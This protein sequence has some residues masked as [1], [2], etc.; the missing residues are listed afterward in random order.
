MPR[1]RGSLR[2][3]GDYPPNSTLLT[4]SVTNQTFALSFRW[5]SVHIV[6]G[7]DED[8][9][10]VEDRLLRAGE[11]AWMRYDE[12]CQPE[13]RR[14]FQTNLPFRLKRGNP[15]PFSVMT[16]VERSPSTCESDYR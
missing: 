7:E 6:V 9:R 11:V 13:N 3:G 10:E 1:R 5:H 4:Q 12:R 15:A 14:L 16:P 8:W 2:T